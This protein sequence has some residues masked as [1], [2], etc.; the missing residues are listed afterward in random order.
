MAEHQQQC[1]QE[2]GCE[3]EEDALPSPIRRR[4]ISV[5]GIRSKDVERCLAPERSYPR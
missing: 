2:R 4:R 1:R 5:G 3:I